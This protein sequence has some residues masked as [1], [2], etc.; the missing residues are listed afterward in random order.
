VLAY[1]QLTRSLSCYLL[2][3]NQFVAINWKSLQKG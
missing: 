3:T 2:I 1:R